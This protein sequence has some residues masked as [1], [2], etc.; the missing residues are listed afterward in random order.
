MVFL[1]GVKTTVQN[2]VRNLIIIIRR[3]QSSFQ[4]FTLAAFV[5]PKLKLQKVF[6]FL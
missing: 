2:D 4:L 3:F 6:A 5:V 1:D